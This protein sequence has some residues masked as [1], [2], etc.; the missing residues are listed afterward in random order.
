MNTLKLCSLI[1]TT[2]E[3]HDRFFQSFRRLSKNLNSLVH[4]IVV[5]YSDIYSNRC[6]SRL[7][8]LIYQYLLNQYHL[9]DLQVCFNFFSGRFK[10]LSC[11]G[12]PWIAS[13]ISEFVNLKMKIA[14]S[15]LDAVHQH[16]VNPLGQP[17]SFL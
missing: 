16:F 4:N 3:V 11:K 2:K 15:A 10:H 6:P 8:Q 5:M 1:L 7:E 9:R 12:F 13:V 17:L 14:K